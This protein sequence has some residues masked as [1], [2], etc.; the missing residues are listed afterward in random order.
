MGKLDI[1]SRF[2][3][4]SIVDEQTYSLRSADNVTR[5]EREI[6]LAE[7]RP[8]TFYGIALNGLPQVLVAADRGATS[9]NTHSV[10]VIENRLCLAIG[11]HVIALSLPKLETLWA[12]AV[13]WATCFGI[14]VCRARNILISHGE[15]EIAR[16][17]EDGE[18]VWRSSG[19]DIFTGHFELRPEWIEARDWNDQLY[20][21]EY[22]TGASL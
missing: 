20:R 2:G 9:V 12:K 19:A 16:L 15:L 22:E 8:C 11:N 3:K 10:V 14:H 4:I 6:V 13:D 21:F 1:D 5:Y 18:I 17:T 7:Y